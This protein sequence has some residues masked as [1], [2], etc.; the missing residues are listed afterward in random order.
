M[1]SPCIHGYNFLAEKRNQT[2]AFHFVIL[3]LIATSSILLISLSVFVVFF[4]LLIG[5]KKLY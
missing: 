2:I 4:F 3:A 1:K 5:E